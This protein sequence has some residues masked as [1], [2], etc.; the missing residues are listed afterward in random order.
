MSTRARVAYVDS[1]ALVKLVVPEPE[2]EAL[3]AELPHWDRHVSSA[4]ARVEVARACA[5]VDAR[6]ARLAQR[7][8]SAL[9]LI[10]VDDALLDDAARLGPR[11]LRSLDAIHV[12]SALLVRDIL[13][14]AITYDERMRGALEA[15]GVP[16]AAP[17]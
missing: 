9:D 1:S 11:E 17:S 15:A 5:R 14:V 13:G 10:A 3:R 16:T 4:L 12:A 2:S 6:A 8:V 7:V